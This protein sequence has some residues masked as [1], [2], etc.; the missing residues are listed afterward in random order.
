MLSS[1]EIKRKGKI[2]SK[3]GSELT[4]EQ[5]RAIVKRL[6][7]LGKANYFKGGKQ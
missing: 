7:D 1:P 2:W 5:A 4:S 6:E 3:A